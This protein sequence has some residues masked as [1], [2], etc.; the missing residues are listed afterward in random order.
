MFRKETNERSPVRV[1][2]RSIHGGLGRGN[3]GVVCSRAGV[4][5]TAFLVGVALD[6]LMRERKVLHINTVDPVEKVRAFYDE[7]FQELAE[8]EKLKDRPTIHLA[9]ERNRMIHTYRHGAFSVAKVHSAIEFL[10]EHMFFQPDAVMID[11]YPDWDTASEQQLREL[12]EL[13]AQLRAELWLTALTHRDDKD[14]DER[15]VPRRISR[16][17]EYLTV[18]VRLTSVADHVKLQLVKDHDNPDVADL[19]LELEPTTLLLRWR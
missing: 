5:K 10:R 3:I 18:I 9:M 16:F 14:L 12:K 11:G 2:E 8:S 1:F 7:V 19:H 15:G 6:D 4:G 13:A 17:E